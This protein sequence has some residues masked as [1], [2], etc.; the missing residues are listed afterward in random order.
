MFQELFILMKDDIHCPAD[1][2]V[3]NNTVWLCLARL[4]LGTGS[5]ELV[6]IPFAIY[7]ICKILSKIS[8][9]A[10]SL[11]YHNSV[12]IQ[13]HSIDVTLQVSPPPDPKGLLSVSLGF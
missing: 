10:V 3:N 7:L 4:F 1:C 9:V 8:G 5:L 12:C 2:T 13:K 11:C 6:F